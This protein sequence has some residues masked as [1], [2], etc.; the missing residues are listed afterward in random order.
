MTLELT[1]LCNNRRADSSKPGPK[2]NPESK[3]QLSLAS[4]F[5]NRETK[6]QKRT[7]LPDCDYVT[8]HGGASCCQRYMCSV[9]D[10]YSPELVQSLRGFL[11]RLSHADRCTFWDHRSEFDPKAKGKTGSPGW[12]HFLETP[13]SLAAK[14]L[15][16]GDG[17]TFIS[18][19]HSDSKHTVCSRWFRWVT[20][21][22]GSVLA[23]EERVKG[24]RD[25]RNFRPSPSTQSGRPYNRSPDNYDCKKAESV[26]SFF[27]N[28]R[29]TY[30]CLPNEDVTIIPF[31]SC[32][33][34]HA[35]YALE[36]EEVLKCPWAAAQR[37]K[38]QQVV[39][40]DHED[41]GLGNI[42]MEPGDDEDMPLRQP[43]FEEADDDHNGG[44]GVDGPLLILHSP[45]PADPDAIYR[46]GNSYLGLLDNTPLSKDIASY[47]YFCKVW[48]ADK[49][50]ASKCKV[51]KYIPFA[52]CDDCSKFK[53]AEEETV[54][55]AH[56]KAL[57]AIQT[58]HIQDVKRE[59]A[60]YA[61]NKAK[62][63]AQ[64]ETYMSIVIDGADQSD[65]DL[66]H[67]ATKSHMVQIHLKNRHDDVI[68]FPSLAL[69]H[70]GI[71]KKTT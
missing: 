35:N 36:M 71:I 22:S 27:R 49:E 38:F 50:V 31:V 29:T 52:K 55:P 59:R 39:I 69:H 62:A 6:K 8:A 13:I 67:F 19:P 51:R 66:P 20:G 9:Q 43:N 40:P 17:S 1:F 53:K 42:H 60:K 15:Q 47:R 48:R 23:Y 30:E 68:F 12:S 63:I 4:R 37:K 21:L 11:L 58:R 34:C 46:Y 61:E 54:N 24:V 44:P 32:K 45:V 16:A 56:R 18:P 26:K 2:V 14:L 33:D 57:R 10:H 65:H 25:A 7:Q 3:H 5:L 41:E 64:P 70:F 28:C